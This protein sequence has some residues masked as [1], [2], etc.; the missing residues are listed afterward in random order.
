V[1]AVGGELQPPPSNWTGVIE[2]TGTTDDL[3]DLA[4]PTLTQLVQELDGLILTVRGEERELTTLS[5]V[6]ASDAVGSSEGLTTIPF[7]F[8]QPGL[9]DRFLRLAARPEAAFFFLVAGLTVAVFEMYAIGPGVAAAA[10]AISLFLS[11]YGLSVLPVRWWAVG[12]AVAAIGAMTASVQK[13]GVL[14]LVILGS[15]L[16]VWSGFNFTTGQPQ[17][18]PSVAGVIFAILAVLFFFLLAIPTVARARF[19]TQII[20]R[21]RLIGR[22]GRAL[23][24]FGFDG[25]PDGLVEIDG[26]RWPATSHREAR[27]DEGSQVVVVG[28]QGWRVEVDPFPSP[29]RENYP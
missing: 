22:S 20:G 25:L 4:V 13:G 5:A 7:T 6:A 12:A 14:A 10:A 17:V 8:T 18:V 21:D 3:I 15:A 26:A 27:I 1:A 2:V 16:L 9:W 23:T 29:V 28:V 19:S 11:A 24:R